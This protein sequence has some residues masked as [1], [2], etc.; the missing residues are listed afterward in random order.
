MENA[1]TNHAV[2][3]K[4]NPVNLYRTDHDLYS[5]VRSQ[6]YTYLA[7]EGFS[8]RNAAIQCFGFIYLSDK[9]FYEKYCHAPPS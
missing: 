6:F 8:E 2:Y 4:K 5:V 1:K 9:W 7:R 3:Y